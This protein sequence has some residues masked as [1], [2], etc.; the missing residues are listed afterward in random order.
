MRYQTRTLE[1]RDFDTLMRLEDEIFA[2]DGESVLGPYYLR[3]CCDFYADTSFVVESGGRVAGY[4]LSFVKGREAYCT[5]LAVHP[6]FQGSRVVVMLLRALAQSIHDSVD[7][8]WF[9]VKPDNLAARQLH[10]V[11]G[12]VE[13]GLLKDFYHAG[14]ARIVSYIDRDGLERMRGRYER[15]GLVAEAPGVVAAND[16]GGVE[17]LARA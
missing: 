4:L 3:L 1:S 12:A 7:V 15:L 11:L 6:D 8:V 5:T 9:T 17:S 10:A 14:D 2:A 16:G 13:T